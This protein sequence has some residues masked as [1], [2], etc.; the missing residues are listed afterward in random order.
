M[1]AITV[2]FGGQEEVGVGGSG[3]WPIDTMVEVSMISA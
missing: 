3:R 1:H 2:D